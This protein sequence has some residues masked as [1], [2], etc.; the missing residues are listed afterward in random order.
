MHSNIYNMR[1]YKGISRKDLSNLTN[2]SDHRLRALESNA[3]DIKLE[4]L[5]DISIA[6]DCSILDLIDDYYFSKII[7]LNNKS[8]H[9]IIK[10][11][12]NLLKRDKY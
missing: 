2:I 9:D 8:L 3:N 6:L 4:E 1:K 5:I 12:N 10:L 7:E 11:A